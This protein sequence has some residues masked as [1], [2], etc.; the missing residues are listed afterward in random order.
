MRAP[1]TPI[2]SGSRRPLRVALFT[3][4]DEFAG[5]ERHILA[6]AEGLREGGEA[7][8]QIACLVPSALAERAR[9]SGLPIIAIQKRG[10]IDLPAIRILRKMLAAGELDLVHSHNG[11]STFSA[12]L[13]VACAQTGSCVATQHFL[14]PARLKSTGVKRMIRTVA[15]R[16]TNS[17]VNHVLAISEA[18]RDA[19]VSRRDAPPEKITVVPNGI[20]EPPLD[21]MTSHEAIRAEFGIAKDAPL[22][23]CVARI[24]REKDI[25]SLVAAMAIV[26]ASDPEARCL[27]VGHGAQ[28]AALSRQILDAGLER[29]VTLTGFRSNAMAFIRAAD[30]FVLP[31]LAE[32]FGLVILEAMALGKPV[33][34][35]AMGGPLEIVVS[36]ETGVLVPPSAP[37]ELADAIRR[38]LADPAAR[39]AMGRN[40]RRRFEERFTAAR[41][42]RET[43]LV[44]KRVL[45]AARKPDDLGQRGRPTAVA[46]P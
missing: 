12:A 4:A 38:L 32:P 26:A 46:H 19:M 34:A 3:D 44:Y 33:V 45:D 22:I 25:P 40:G 2:P 5:T 20:S 15:H 18:V 31:S 42:A 37:G 6:L 28:Q 24:E 21:S 1:T 30:L 35:T 41:A 9:E 23:V 39:A 16:W 29:V 8:V 27:I 7:A 14:E 17:R 13:A 36:G 10:M 11:R 43:L